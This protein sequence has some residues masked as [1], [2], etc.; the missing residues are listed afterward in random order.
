MILR[1]LVGHPAPVDQPERAGSGSRPMKMFS[2]TVRRRDEAEFL[3]DRDD[4]EAFRLVR[5]LAGVSRLAVE[6]DAC[7]H[8]GGCAPERILSKRRLAGAVLAEQ[9]D[10]SRRAPD[11]QRDVVAAPATPGKSC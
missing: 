10:E 4:A 7:R 5:R 1:G 9:A 3:V 11:L 2:A 6:G 8:R